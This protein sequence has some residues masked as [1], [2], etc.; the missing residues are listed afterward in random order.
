MARGSREQA[1]AEPSFELGDAAADRRLRQPEHARRAPEA[2]CIDD[3]E[4]SID[5]RQLIFTHRKKA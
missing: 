2:S 3:R 1:H 5:G 4:E